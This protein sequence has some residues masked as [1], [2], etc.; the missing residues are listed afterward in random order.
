M[1]SSNPGPRKLGTNPQITSI[2]P[3]LR[4]A[5][6]HDYLREYG[7]AERVL[8]ALHDMYPDAPVFTAFTDP[9]S[10]GKHWHRFQ[11]WDIRQSWAA[12]IPFIHKLYSPLRI[13]SASFFRSFDLKKFDFV[14]SST[15]MYMAKAI[16]VPRGKHI[17]YCHTPPRSLYGFTT[18]T[19]WRK[20]LIIRFFGEIIN[21]YMRMV[22]FYTAQNPTQFIANSKTVMD[23]IMKYYKR[24]SILVYPPIRVPSELPK[25]NP[26]KHPAQGKPYFLFV[27][28]LAYSKH[29]DLV[30]RAC[31]QE[32]KTLFVIGTG[33]ARADLEKLPL[34]TTTFL[35]SVSD[36]ELSRWYTYATA[37]VYPAEDEDFGMIPVEAM[38]HGTPVIVHR[39]GGFL[40]T[41]VEGKTG[42]FVDG[43]SLEE[44]IAALYKTEAHSWNRSA[45]YEHAKKYSVERFREEMHEVVRNLQDA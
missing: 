32:G 6:A 27:G 15:N 3:Q 5:L 25:Q 2:S 31:E 35:D 1:P 19:N 26:K 36:D 12:R 7:G 10:M 11:N 13:L 23:R 40:E 45:L 9:K 28:R 4:V 39:S 41:V 43:F 21:H 22:D 37:V 8:E 20:N 30:V 18:M 16:R 14:I 38:A 34:K 44:M 17:T 42:M 29:L 33:D 24:T